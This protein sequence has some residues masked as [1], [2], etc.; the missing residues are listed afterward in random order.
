MSFIYVSRGSASRVLHAAFR[1]PHEGS[2]FLQRSGIIKICR[3][4][5]V[6]CNKG[7][8]VFIG[9]EAIEIN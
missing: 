5:V 8:S 6:I 3:V 4:L 9:P 1:H 2:L 7:F